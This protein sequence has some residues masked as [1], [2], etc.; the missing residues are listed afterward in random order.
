[1]WGKVKK[2]VNCKVRQD[3]C[4]GDYECKNVMLHQIVS[5]MTVLSIIVM[6]LNQKCSL[7][8]IR[9]KVKRSAV[10]SSVAF[11]MTPN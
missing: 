11:C 4:F 5:I 6:S 7:G 10:S 3:T 2:Q 9:G 1:M 8:G